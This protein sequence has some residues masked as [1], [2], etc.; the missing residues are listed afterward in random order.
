[1]CRRRTLVDVVE[2][3]K[4]SSG[5]LVKGLRHTGCKPCRERLFDVAAMTAIE[6]A[7]KPS[8]R[9]RSA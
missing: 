7:R 3:C 6:A 5:R 1:M 2:D 8:T 9:K 4:L